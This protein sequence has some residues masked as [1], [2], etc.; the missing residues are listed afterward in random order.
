MI[1]NLFIFIALIVAH[2]APPAPAKAD[3]LEWTMRNDYPYTIYVRFFSKTY[4]NRAWPGGN[5]S[6]IFNDGFDKTVRLACEP[7]EY[8]CFGGFT[9]SRQSYWG[10]G[11][12]GNQGCSTCCRYCGEFYNTTDVLN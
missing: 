2:L 8:I 10:V 11:E 1:R 4:N 6:Y 5:D 7:G 3:V 9:Q 12:Y